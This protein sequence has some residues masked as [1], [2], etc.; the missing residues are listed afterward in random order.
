MSASRLFTYASWVAF[1]VTGT[2]FVSGLAKSGAGGGDVRH[3]Q[4]NVPALAVNPRGGYDSQGHYHPPNPRDV[5]I[6][7]DVYDF[8]FAPSNTIIKAGQAI[9]FRG[10]GKQI[11]N[12]VPTTEAGKAVFR[13][14]DAEGSGRPIFN[15]PGVYPYMCVIHPQMKGTVTVVSHF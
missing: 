2:L 12:I 6:R 15:K 8:G 5:P 3:I 10:V 11:H 9:A 13:A 14:A 1:L 4:A 7:I